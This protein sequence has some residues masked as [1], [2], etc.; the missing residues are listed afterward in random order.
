MLTYLDY[1]LNK[2]KQCCEHDVVN[3]CQRC[4]LDDQGYH[5][6]MTPPNPTQ[7]S[8]RCQRCG[9]DNAVKTMTTLCSM[10]L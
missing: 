7:V 9:D 10:M 5:E 8:L 4:A 6:S 1:M 2:P 3:I